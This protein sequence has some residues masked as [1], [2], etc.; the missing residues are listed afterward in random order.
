MRFFA[1]LAALLLAL[2]PMAPASVL[3]AQAAAPDPDNTVQGAEEDDARIK[4]QADGA[5]PDDDPAADD[6]ED[7][8]SVV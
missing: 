5:A 3:W 8:K 7:R 1:W 2:G 6:E 4:L